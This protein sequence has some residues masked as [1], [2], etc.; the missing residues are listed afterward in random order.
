MPGEARGEKSR[1]YGR[2]PTWAAALPNLGGRTLAVLAAIAHHA[3]AEGRA[4]PAMSTIAAFAGIQRDK[5]P[6]HLAKLVAAGVLR[7]KLRKDERGNRSNLYTVIYEPPIVVFPH[8]GT[9]VARGGNRVLPQGEAGGVAADG[10]RT[11]QFGTQQ[12]TILPLG[13]RAR[14]RRSDFFSLAEFQPNTEI[15][16]WAAEHVPEVNPLDPEI[17]AAFKDHYASN[18]KVTND[19]DAAYRQWIRKEP[20]FSRRRGPPNSGCSPLIRSLLKEAAKTE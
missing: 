13:A 1:W 19:P 16:S 20:A 14:A 15:V 17:I 7:K 2:F 8:K 12:G 3:D 9:P 10:N 6:H 11:E 18:G 4:Y 5:V